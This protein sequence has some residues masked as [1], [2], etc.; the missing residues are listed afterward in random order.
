MQS[1]EKRASL[2]LL[3]RHHSATMT[4]TPMP[5]PSSKRKTDPDPRSPR[6]SQLR[7]KSADS[8]SLD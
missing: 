4:P 1:P 5:P 2:A 8:S 6:S 7:R 3:W